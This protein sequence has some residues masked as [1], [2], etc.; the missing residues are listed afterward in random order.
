GGT[1]NL[2]SVDALQE[3]RI[4]TSTFAPEFGRTPGA[5][6]QIVTRSGAN[7]FSGNVFDYFRND[8]LDANDWFTNA[9]RLRKPALRQ[10]DFGGVLGGPIIKDKTFFFFSYEGLRLRQPVTASGRLVPSLSLRQ[11]AATALRPFL[12]AFPIPNGRDFGVLAEFNASFSNPSTLNATSIR[13]D[14]NLGSRLALF[15][16]YNHAPS[17][18]VSRGASGISLSV[19]T[20]IRNETDTLT[21]GATW[22][23]SASKSNELRFNYTRTGGGSSLVFDGLGGGVA[24]P[25]SLLFPSPFSANDS[26][27]FVQ[28]FNLALYGV[29]RNADNLQRQINVVDNYSIAHA[30][31]SLKFGVDYRRLAPTL[32][33]AA[34]RQVLLFQTPTSVMPTPPAPPTASIALID[35]NETVDMFFTNFSAYGQD[36]WKAGRRLTLTYGLRW[37]VNPPP[38]GAKGRE[39]FAV[40][41]FD[42]FSV[43]AQPCLR[44]NRQTS[45]KI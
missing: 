2:V 4:Q 27:G 12:N 15:G 28:F 20:P 36:T 39:P 19:F 38:S 14:H 16:R 10:N 3:F 43:T 24:P 25:D 44:E 21:M 41:G 1:N 17:E 32:K 34:Y 7:Q 22:A 35:N 5:Q 26:V 9:N 11:N 6:V 30:S 18:T 37:D 40:T 42:K 31:H 29:G 23:I 33:P 13:I 45:E 8:A